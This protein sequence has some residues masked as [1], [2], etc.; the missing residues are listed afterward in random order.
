[1]I[2]FTPRTTSEGPLG[3]NCCAVLGKI[4]IL[5]LSF[6]PPLGLSKKSKNF[7]T[8]LILTWYTR[9]LTVHAQRLLF[10]FRVKKLVCN[11]QLFERCFFHI[12]QEKGENLNYGRG[13]DL[14][15]DN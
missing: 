6:Q 1:M 15:F 3:A 14:K 8:L 7:L 2:F 10:I 9:K 5:V 13:F 11:T 12:C 4:G